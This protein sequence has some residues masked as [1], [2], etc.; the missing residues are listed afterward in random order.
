MEKLHELRIDEPPPEPARRGGGG[1]GWVILGLLLAAAGG[2]FYWWMQQGKPIPQTP[3]PVPVAQPAPVPEPTPAVDPSAG[4]AVL[5]ELL[6]GISSAPE[7]ARWMERGLIRPLVAAVNLVA[8]GESPSPVVPFMSPNKAFKVK[9][10]KRALIIDPKSYAR[11]DRLTKIFDSLD[12]AATRAAYVKLQ[13]YIDAA[14]GEIGKPGKTFNEVLKAAMDRLIAVPIPKGPVKVR[15]D[16]LTYKFVDAELE[17]R[18]PAEKH[19]LRMGP[20]NM[21]IV[22][23]KLQALRAAL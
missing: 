6:A 3:V 12:V 16:G 7:L 8:A 14:Y 2:G 17:G 21:R 13:P 4:E 15:R 5:K 11:Y 18:T 22:Q 20:K 23:A 9:K 10:V 19:L 1:A